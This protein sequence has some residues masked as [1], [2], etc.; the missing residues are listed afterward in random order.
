MSYKY[1]NLFCLD[2]KK[3]LFIHIP[4]TAGTSVLCCLNKNRDF[5]V[6]HVLLS[7]YSLEFLENFFIFTTVRNPFDRFVSQWIYHTTDTDNF[8]YRIYKK[9][10]DI[11]SYFDIVKEMNDKRTSWRSMSEFIHHKDKKIDFIMKFEN[12]SYDWNLFK[13]KFNF[14]C[15]LPLIKKTKHDHYSRYYN[16]LLISKVEQMYEQDLVNFNYNFQY[17]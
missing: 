7:R 12:L 1:N 9:S 3:I 11:F 8:F 14:R 16:S 15:D 10:M 5:K 4:K 6:G 17:E 13:N 2:S